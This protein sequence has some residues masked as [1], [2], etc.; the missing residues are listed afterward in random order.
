[1]LS[2]IPVSNFLLLERLGHSPGRRQK[3][4]GKPA[5]VE[6]SYFVQI[7]KKFNDGKQ[8]STVRK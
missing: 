3:P 1:M 8:I 2:S 4:A 7:E 6:M 5:L